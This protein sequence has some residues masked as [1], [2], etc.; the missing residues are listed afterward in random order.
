M[1]PTRRPT[2]RGP[3]VK[4]EVSGCNNNR[5]FK[6]NEYQIREYSR[7]CDDH[8]CMARKPQVATP[9][10]PKRRESGALFCGKHQK[11]G[12]GIGNCLQYGEY[13][14][15]HLPWVCGEHKCALP[16][17]RQPRDID[18]YHCR[19][20]R[21]LGYPLKCAIEPCIGVGQEDSTFCINHGC[22][23]S[24]C[25]GRAEDDRRCHEHRP[26]LKNG[27]ER[28]AQERRDFCIGHAYCDIED[29]SNVAEY[30]ARY[31]PEHECISKSCSN[32]R[33]GRSEFCQNLKTNASS[34]DVS[35]RGGLG[36]THAHSIAN[37]TSV[38]KAGA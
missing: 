25:G 8:T 4:C 1:P 30:G 2:H 29:C 11:C 13:P 34:M 37:T 14:D 18:T 21:S 17:C 19:D 31:C 26:C 28:F 22:A 38:K 20:H 36:A 32:V 33:K 9:F 7:F 23:I 27:C 3:K 6:K 10:C 5:G 16:Q 15:R 12:G 35:S 24:G